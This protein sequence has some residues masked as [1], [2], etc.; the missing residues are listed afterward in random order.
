MTVLRTNP[1]LNALGAL[2]ILLFLFQRASAGEHPSG[3]FGELLFKDDFN[4]GLSQLHPE[5]E[6]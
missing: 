5:L 3:R 6:R 2:V 1:F 4:S